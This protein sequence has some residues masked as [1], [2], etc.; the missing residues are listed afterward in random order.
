MRPT[1]T[2]VNAGGGSLKSIIYRNATSIY[3]SRAYNLQ[4]RFSLPLI[5]LAIYLSSLSFAESLTINF[6]NA[7]ERDDADAE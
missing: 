3:R 6:I 4:K 5:Y 7:R 1:N 2:G